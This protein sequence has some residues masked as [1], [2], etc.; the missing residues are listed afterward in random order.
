[1]I[2]DLNE[3][4]APF[5]EGYEE[6]PEY[7]AQELSDFAEAVI[8]TFT[9]AEDV[10]VA[11]II[12]ATKNSAND[13]SIFFGLMDAGLGLEL[14][15]ST[16]ASKVDKVLNIKLSLDIVPATQYTSVLAGL[17][18]LEKEGAVEVLTK[19]EEDKYVILEELLDLLE[20]YK[21][22]GTPEVA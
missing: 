16:G 17:T 5:A 14:D 21:L 12:N 6:E 2:A 20:V 18:A 9:G 8:G 1:M 4:L 7:T 19:N 22:I 10:S 3:L 15:I 11:D 13:V